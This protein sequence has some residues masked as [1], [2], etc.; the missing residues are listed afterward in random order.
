MD[1][2]DLVRA[3]AADYVYQQGRRAVLYL[4]DQE[5][6]AANQ[7]DALSA[8]AWRDIAEAAAS[9]LLKSN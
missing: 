1:D 8:E 6:I 2:A 3:V 4:R 9:I 7:G 5:K